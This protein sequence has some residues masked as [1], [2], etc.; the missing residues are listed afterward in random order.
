MKELEIYEQRKQVQ[1]WHIKFHEWLLFY[2]LYIG[3][4]DY[5]GV[6]HCKKCRRS[7][8]FSCVYFSTQN[9]QFVGEYFPLQHPAEDL[10]YVVFSAPIGIALFKQ[11]FC[12]SLLQNLNELLEHWK[13][14]VWN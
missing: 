9:I 11:F 2:V 7:A 6:V 5:V 8:F 10:T 12:F 3:W 13:R 14:I 1:K 4:M